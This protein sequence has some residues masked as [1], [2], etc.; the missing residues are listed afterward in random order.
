M[1]HLMVQMATTATTVRRA[2]QAILVQTATMVR[3]GLLARTVKTA[4]TVKTVSMELAPQI[5]V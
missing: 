4:K 1:Q 2:L 5:R 3:R